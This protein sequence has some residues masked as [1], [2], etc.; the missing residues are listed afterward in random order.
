MTMKITS[1]QS[2]LVKCFSLKAIFHIQQLTKILNTHEWGP[3]YILVGPA[4][5]AK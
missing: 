3:T 5:K 4:I 1:S 2:I